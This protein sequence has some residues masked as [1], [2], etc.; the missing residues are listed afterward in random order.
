MT[1]YI[2]ILDDH[3]ADRKHLERLFDREHSYRESIG[4]TIYIDSFGNSD[5][6]FKTPYRYDLFIIDISGEN[7]LSSMEAAEKVI[8]LGIEATIVICSAGADDEA[9]PVTSEDIHT[10]KTDI[11]FEKKPLYKDDIK[12][13]VDT[14]FERS[15]KKTPLI[16]IRCKDG[17]VFAP[18]T[19]F[20]YALNRDR[21]YL[22]EIHL[23]DGRVLICTENMSQFSSLLLAY[24]CMVPCG[25]DFVN[26]SHVT[27]I[28]PGSLTLSDG[29]K[30]HFPL[31]DYPSIKKKYQGITGVQ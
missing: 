7:D 28:K 27:G 5:A 15:A 19:D 30:L 6:L 16:E 10:E 17:T 12:R 22:T 21:Q 3:I 31:R 13:L 26:L 2:A 23:S 29:K 20:S 14:A 25:R 1:L 24:D 18:Y 9:D 4:Q 8:G 11:I